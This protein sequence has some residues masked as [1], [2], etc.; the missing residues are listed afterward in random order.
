MATGNRT[1]SQFSA[2]LPKAPGW[3]WF[4]LDI[5]QAG[6]GLGAPLEWMRLDP[7]APSLRIRNVQLVEADMKLQRRAALGDMADKLD[8]LGISTKG[9]SG[10]PCGM[11]TV[12]YADQASCTIV[13]S[14][15][16]HLDLDARAKQESKQDH[17][18]A[19]VPLGPVLA[20]GEG[21]RLDNHTVV[22]ILDKYQ[23]Q[24]VQFLA[25]P[26]TVKG[27]VGIDSLAFE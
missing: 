6:K 25:Y 24:E 1:R 13:K 23:L 18:R 5:S 15:Y 27:G 11:E 8:T 7:P 17:A 26:P 19:L 16:G 12:N 20:T 14:V 3:T 9:I 2:A 22:R 21:E 10:D 4:L